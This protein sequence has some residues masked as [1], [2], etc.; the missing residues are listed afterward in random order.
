MPLWPFGRRTKKQPITSPQSSALP[1][2]A[3]QSS[4]K[5]IPKAAPKPITCPH[6]GVVLDI[7]PVRKRKCPECRQ[8]IVPKQALG[9]VKRFYTEEQ[10]LAIDEEIKAARKEKRLR[11]LRI[12]LKATEKAGDKVNAMILRAQIA[13]TNDDRD[14]AWRCWNEATIEAAKQCQG[15]LY[16]IIRFCQAEQLLKEGRTQAAIPF[17]CEVLYLDYCR[18]TNI[19]SE[20]RRGHRIQVP[21]F[22][23]YHRAELAKCGIH[24][25]DYGPNPS[26][27]PGVVSRLARAA[28]EVGLS[29]DQLGKLF[30]SECQERGKALQAPYPTTDAWRELREY[31]A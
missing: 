13:L 12:Q 11:D 23:K 8:T 9:D 17:L 5:P 2:A 3:P 15:G 10:A 19:W 27:A 7:E 29:V 31:L 30:C 1:P 4:A 14:G 28:E 24:L 26:F 21:F 22:E 16:R 25:E 18:V 6:C 20:D